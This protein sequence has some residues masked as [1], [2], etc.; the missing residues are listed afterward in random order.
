MAVRVL[1]ADSSGI[2]REILRRHLQCMGC[3]VVAETENVSQTVDLFRTVKPDVV[4]LDMGLNRIGE[5]D[6]VTLFRLIRREGPDTSIIMVSAS[7]SPDNSRM[8]MREGAL[9]CVVEPFDSVG[10]EPMWRALSTRYPELRRIEAAAPSIAW[11]S[12]SHRA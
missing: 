1:I 10:F 12:G 7:H 6:L 3:E 11:R 4:T 5:V 2:T 8:F 9:D